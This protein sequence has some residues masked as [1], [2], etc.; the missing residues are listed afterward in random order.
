MS[1]RGQCA[2]AHGQS[3]SLNGIEKSVFHVFAYVINPANPVGAMV[4]N[5]LLFDLN[6]SY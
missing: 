4:L 2:G 6:G 5:S 1:G 3:R